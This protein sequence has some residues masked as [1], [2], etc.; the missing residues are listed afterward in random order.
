MNIKVITG[1]I[2]NIAAD[3]VVVG[4]VEGAQLN[5]AAN[6]FDQACDALISNVIA[7]GEFKAKLN[8][9]ITLYPVGLAAK[10]LVLV[11]LGEAEKLTIE[12]LRQAAGSAIKTAVKGKPVIVATVVHGVGINGIESRI[13]AEALAE[14]MTL[15]LYRYEELKSKKTECTLQEVIVVAQE[16]CDKEAVEAGIKKGQTLAQ[17]TN[18]ARDLVNAPG[19]YMTPTHMAEVAVQIARET[20]MKCTILERADMEQLG[21]GALLGVAQG[22]AQPPKMIVLHHEGN[23]GGETLALVGKG[24]TFDSGGISL[25]PGEGMWLMKDDMAGGAAVIG[26]MKAIGQLK[27]KANVLGIVAASENLPSGTALKPGDVIRAM[28]GKTIE[29]ISTDAEGRLILADAVAYAVKLGASKVVDVATLTGA[30]GV[31]LGNVYSAI[32]ANNN[33]LVAEIKAASAVSGE[34]FWQ[35]PNDD[36]YKELI[37]S[38]VADVKNSGGRMGGVMTGGLFIGEFVGDTPWAHL[39]IAPQAYTE[40]EKPCQPKGATGVATRTLVALACK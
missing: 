19:N 20:G 24:L 10:K 5:G 40:S 31:A 30:C 15:A 32:V 8:E 27:P 25:K 29:I 2:L 7:Q 37:K 39:D 17:A 23:P 4:V 1:D 35:M 21:M 36:D 22:S 6:G 12:R 34:R 28:T 11:G 18:L 13:A 14:G 33:D 3:A 38:P 9:T 16:C 26:A